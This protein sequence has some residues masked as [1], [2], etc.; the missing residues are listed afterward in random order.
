MEDLLFKMGVQSW[1]TDIITPLPSAPASTNFQIGK[2]LAT[3]VGFIYGVSVYADG[4]D[5]VGNPLISTTQAQGIYV[6]WQNGS[7]QFYETVRLDDYL[8]TFAGTP[9][10]RPDKY[11]RVNWPTFDLSK[12][13]FNNPFLYTNATIRIKL[14]YVQIED[15]NLI[16]SE[17][18]FGLNALEA[19]RQKKKAGK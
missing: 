6:T 10:V 8:N 14:Y 11:T 13:F 5:P 2:T 7:S 9:V 17:Y 18:P 12:S 1:A 4:I 3:N 16:K 19:Q 15:W